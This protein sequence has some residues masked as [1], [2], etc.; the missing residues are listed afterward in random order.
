MA[1]SLIIIILVL[2]LTPILILILILI[3]IPI[4]ILIL[5]LILTLVLILILIL[6]EFCRVA[7]SASL[8]RPRNRSTIVPLPLILRGGGLVART[9]VLIKRKHPMQ[10]KCKGLDGR[11][12]IFTPKAYSAAVKNSE[13]KFQKVIVI[14]KS[15]AFQIQ[16][17]CIPNQ[18]FFCASASDYHEGLWF[19]LQNFGWS[20]LFAFLQWKFQAPSIV[21]QSTQFRMAKQGWSISNFLPS[22]IWQMSI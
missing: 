20:R 16:S 11:A 18:S 21:Y 19:I 17:F 15:C 12:Q 2:I 14:W 5:I 13:R 8:G 10:Y 7:A 4:P 9:A 6:G 3:L 1:C 22:F